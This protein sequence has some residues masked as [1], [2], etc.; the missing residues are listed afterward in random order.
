MATSAAATAYD[1]DFLVVIGNGFVV[2][3]LFGMATENADS[4]C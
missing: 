3:A 2:A 1:L 4:L